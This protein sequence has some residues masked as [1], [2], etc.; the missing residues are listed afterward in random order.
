MMKTM[1]TAA[2]LAMAVGVS[3]EAQDSPADALA[4]L[5]ALGLQVELLGATG[6]GET[7]APPVGQ[8]APGAVNVITG[9]AGASMS[10][11]TL[12]EIRERFMGALASFGDSFSADLQREIERGVRR[13]CQLSDDTGF[14]L[15]SVSLSVLNIT[16][17]FRPTRDLC[18]ALGPD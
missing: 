16:A 7:G 6:L 14:E 2:V 8:A 10:A 17:T 9:E 3:A 5:N 1:A 11:Q 15:F 12:R 13:A 18:D 4:E